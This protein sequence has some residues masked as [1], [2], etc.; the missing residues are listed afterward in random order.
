MKL[1]SLIGQIGLGTFLCNGPLHCC[2]VEQRS[3]TYDCMRVHGCNQGIAHTATAVTCNDVLSSA[4]RASSLL[5][6]VRCT[7]CG[8]GI[9]LH[10]DPM[11]ITC[12]N[13]IQDGNRI[14]SLV[15]IGLKERDDT[16]ASL[17]P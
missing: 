5:L 9:S 13:V 2:K 12:Q 15:D 16:Q 17:T 6:V 1:R 7:S 3:R 11:L 10:D 8:D 14:D 4:R